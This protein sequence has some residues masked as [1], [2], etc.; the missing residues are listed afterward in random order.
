MDETDASAGQG[1][2]TTDVRQSLNE[3]KLAHWIV[4]ARVLDGLVPKGILT[5]AATL[6][7]KL[8]IRQFGFG[9]SNPTYLFRI[10]GGEF[11]AV[12]RKKPDKVAHASA[13]ALH[14]E[15]RVL[16]ALAKH[17]QLHPDSTVPV[18]KVYAYCKSKHVLGAEFYLMEFVNGRIFTDASM[19]GLSAEERTRAFKSV[20]DT[21]S[22]LHRVNLT[23]VDLETF[24]KKGNYTQRQL[25][26]LVGIC[27]R[28]SELSGKPNLEIEDLA[29]QLSQYA[30]YCP[31]YVS[32]LHGDFK[33]D[34]LIFHP[35]ESRVI[36]VLDWELSTI[37][38]SL[39]DVA[40]MSMMYFMPKSK[41][42]GISGIAGLDLEEL[43][44]P[45]RLSILQEYC[46][47][48]PDVDSTLA[49]DWS[50]YY[51][52]FLFFKN[53]VIVQGVAQRQQD[54]V[55]SSSVAKKVGNLLPIIIRMTQG[56]IDNYVKPSL[57]VIQAPKSNL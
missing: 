40:N 25:R 14:R 55:A 38:D 51:L 44:I 15:Y 29:G 54:G 1:Q 32:L 28:Q 12:L 37:G 41:G 11:A 18:P 36:A 9:Q 10:L 5:S 24:G 30:P 19:P 34:N 20:V 50:G 16:E 57:G 21:L 47:L 52:A 7:A 33:V 13:H 45:S 31:N 6:E 23:E 46:N 42:T 49:G 27:K 56:M 39:C 8:K 53:C 48:R 35:Q 4:D 43:G 22:K 2:S 17:N 26:R 3:L